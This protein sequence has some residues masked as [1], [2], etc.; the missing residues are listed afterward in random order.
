VVDVVL[1][2]AVAAGALQPGGDDQRGGFESAGLAAVDA[3]AVAAGEAGVASVPRREACRTEMVAEVVA[4]GDG[5]DHGQYG[6]FLS[7]WDHA[8]AGLTMIKAVQDRLQRVGRR[9]PEGEKE[10]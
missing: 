1:G 3:G 5:G 9:V 10:G 2:V 4:L 7:H 6:C 8:A